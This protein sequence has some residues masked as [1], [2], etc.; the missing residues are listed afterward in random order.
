MTNACILLLFKENISVNGRKV[1]IDVIGALSRS[2]S[3]QTES[4]TFLNDI[5][6]LKSTSSSGKGFAL[7]VR[8][9]SLQLLSLLV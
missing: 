8:F 4:G 1:L 6:I 5:R 9:Y 2:M 7:T 3:L